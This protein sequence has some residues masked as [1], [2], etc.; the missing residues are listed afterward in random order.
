MDSA[1]IAPVLAQAVPQGLLQLAPMVLILGVFYLLLVRPQQQQAKA[2]E[3]FV[4]GLKRGDVVVTSSG[5]YGR[6]VDVR[7]SDVTLEIA[8]NVRVRYD[9]SKISA[10]A[11]A[12]PATKEG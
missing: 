7:A 9:R 2:H 4:R 10:A 6:I 1:M 3:E 12:A 11:P 8:S 5:L